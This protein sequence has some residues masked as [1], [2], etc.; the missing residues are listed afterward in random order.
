MIVVSFALPAESSVFRRVARRMPDVRVLHTGVGEQV[1]RAAVDRFL[2]G[3]R[4]ELW[5]S[6]GFAGALDDMLCVGDLIVAANYSTAAVPEGFTAQRGSLTTAPEVLDSAADRAQLARR[7]GAIAVD[8]ETA[9]IAEACAARGI[10][11]LAVRA[12]S[13]TPSAPF[14]APPHVLFDV[15][16]QRTSYARLLGY[17]ASRP[18]ALP[19]L[20]AFSRQIGFARSSLASGLRLLLELLPQS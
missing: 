4:P 18:V 19:R 11:L 2:S 10:P 9:F 13:D 5:I 6:S 16:R 3:Q 14:P 20:L 15:A 17:L 12:I 7:T 1:T 8:M